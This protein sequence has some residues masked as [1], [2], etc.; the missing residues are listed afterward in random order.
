M[1]LNI[2]IE[3]SESASSTDSDHHCTCSRNLGTIRDDVRHPVVS[4]DVRR[5]GVIH[6][7]RKIG[8]EL[9]ATAIVILSSN[10]DQHFVE[11][12]KKIGARAYRQDQSSRGFGHSIERAIIDG[13]LVL[14]D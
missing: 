4:N 6:A 14:I 1:A 5:H 3:W 13:E 7:A 8:T 10:A 2:R 11:E 9:P 12:A